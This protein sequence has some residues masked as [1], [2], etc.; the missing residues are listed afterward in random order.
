MLAWLGL[1]KSTLLE[2]KLSLRELIFARWFGTPDGIARRVPGA[3]VLIFPIYFN[4]CPFFLNIPNSRTP[5]GN[6]LIFM[7]RKGNLSAVHIWT[8]Y[9]FSWGGRFLLFFHMFAVNCRCW[10]PAYLFTLCW[11]SY[12]Q[13]LISWTFLFPLKTTRLSSK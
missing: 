2:W 6:Q 11:N 4:W 5:S 12:N 7:S 1:T 13:S 10:S 8:L 3:W 9:L